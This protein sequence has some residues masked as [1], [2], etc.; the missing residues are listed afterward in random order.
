M[1]GGAEG[2]ATGNRSHT[3]LFRSNRMILRQKKLKLSNKN[4]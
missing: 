1:T 3:R 4:I 2:G